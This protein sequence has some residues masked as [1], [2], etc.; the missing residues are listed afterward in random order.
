[1][2]P[3]FDEYSTAYHHVAMTRTDGIIELTLHSDGG[4]LVWGDAPHTELGYCFADVAADPDNRIVILTGAGGKF[5]AD[6]DTSW[7]GGMNPAK[8]DK[9]YQHGR[10]LLQN[11]LAI[12]VPVIAA[13][14]G[15]A[16]VH[17]EL[18]V[19]ADI[20]LAADTADFQDAPHFRY[21]TVPSDGVHIV[22]PHLLGANRGRYFLL[23][24]Q[25]LSA[26][27]A[28]DLGVVSEVLP[29]HEL[30]ARARQLAAQL[31]RQ[32][33]AT[34]RYTRVALTED[35]KRRLSTDLGYGLALEGLAAYQSWP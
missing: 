17:A 19:L 20:V 23:T 32:P 24:G 12:E 15:P 4:P 33:D 11:L 31:A 29:A 14:N 16:R 13:V 1:M 26:R 10:R 28:L 9:I 3:V 8:W 30:M 2:K 27:E 21:G 7:V 22:W 6:L 35:L 34:L 25:R 5:I 18:A